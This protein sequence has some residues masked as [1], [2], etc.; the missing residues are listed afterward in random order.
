[1]TLIF[2]TARAGQAIYRSFIQQAEAQFPLDDTAL[3]TA[4]QVFML[5]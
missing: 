2:M 1:M 4:H 3:T 5:Y